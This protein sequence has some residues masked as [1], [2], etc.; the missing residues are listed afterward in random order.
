LRKKERIKEQKKEKEGRRKGDKRARKKTTKKL[1]GRFLREGID[2]TMNLT[3]AREEKKKK[4]RKESQ[5]GSE[6]KKIHRMIGG[7]EGRRDLRPPKHR[8][9][10]G[11]RERGREGGKRPA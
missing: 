6:G 5:E 3:I 2:V 9:R 4:E 10:G 8:R 11:R 7:R 1:A